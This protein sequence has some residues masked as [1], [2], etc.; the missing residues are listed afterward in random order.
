MDATFRAALTTLLLSTVFFLPVSAVTVTIDETKQHQTIEGF[1][2]FGLSETSDAWAD[3]MINDLGLTM[4]RINT[5]DAAQSIQYWVDLVN[6]F[7]SKAAAADEPFRV[8][9]STWSPPAHMKMN[10][11]VSGMDANTNKL[12]PTAYGSYADVLVNFLDKMKQG[13]GMDL[14]G[15]SMQ[16][17][18]AF[19]EPYWSCVYTYQEY[20]DL[21]K[22]AGPKLK[23]AAPNTKLFMPEDMAG[24]YQRVRAYVETVC[25]DNATRPYVGTVA[26]HGY[27]GDGITAD[28]P[29]ASAWNA[30]G[31]LAGKY[32]LPL[33]MTET[34]G[35]GADW[36]SSFRLAQDIFVALKYGKL[37]AWVFWTITGGSEEY[38]LM[39]GMTPSKKYYAS[40]QFYRY[41]R[42]GAVMLDAASD[43][44]AVQAVAFAHR[45]KKT[46]T[47]V[48]INT[49]SSSQTVSLT[50]ANVPSQLSK[51]VTSSSK[52]CANE[53]T[54]ASGA[55]TVDGSSI[56][57]LVGQ[58]Y[59]PSAVVTSPNPGRVHAREP[60][61]P[62]AVYGI[63]GRFLG[64]RPRGRAGVDR[65]QARGVQCA[66]YGASRARLSAF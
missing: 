58:N 47:V 10:N 39:A 37:S 4:L 15:L 12:K 57:T 49:S 36:N 42:P 28:S 61:G 64:T 30:L 45:E 8:I 18:P 65:L 20:H 44:D 40:K 52:N 27:Q 33:W 56:T 31:I 5:G 60:A 23:A 53:G 22:V 7:K 3:K 21:L 11:S 48:L 24:A 59:T 2:G 14:Y 41:I 34:S 38:R 26:V 54:T 63:D 19:S 35:Y 62:A 50:G 25:R 13:T 55:V 66:V 1:G 29:G 32:D 6:K 51:Y 17:E 43:Q 16:N 46:V 9:A